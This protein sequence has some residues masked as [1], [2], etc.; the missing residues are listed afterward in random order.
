MIAASGTLASAASSRSS[1]TRPASRSPSSTTTSPAAAKERPASASRTAPARSSAA[2]T[3]TEVVAWSAA[4]PSS[5]VAGSASAAAMTATLAGHAC[6]T[7]SGGRTDPRSAGHYG[8]KVPKPAEAEARTG[9]ESLGQEGDPMSLQLV[10]LIC[11]VLLAIGIASN[12]V[13]R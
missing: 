9:G 13:T 2:A 7:A 11:V 8:S 10:F 1:V 5:L 3:G 12:I 6:L 4:T